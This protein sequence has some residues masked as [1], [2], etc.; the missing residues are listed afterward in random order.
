MKQLS[1]IIVLLISFT[2]IPCF[3]QFDDARNLVE[4]LDEMLKDPEIFKAFVSK[5][6]EVTGATDEELSELLENFEGFEDV[7]ENVEDDATNSYVDAVAA[8]ASQNIVDN[9]LD[10]YSVPQNDFL[11]VSSEGLI[12]GYTQ[13]QRNGDAIENIST[14]QATIIP[15]IDIVSVTANFTWSTNFQNR[16]QSGYAECI[17]NPTTFNTTWVGNFN[18][19]D[20]STLLTVVNTQLVNFGEIL[21][22][23]YGVQDDPNL[24]SFLQEY[25]VAYVQV[26]LPIII[27]NNI[28][29]ALQ[30]TLD[31]DPFPLI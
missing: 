25:F 10:K 23:V 27:D 19:G 28:K 12:Q 14:T 15:N 1:F 21:V 11:G 17:G 24:I 5:I 31:N 7:E 8:I 18:E 26:F 16:S 9:N 22:N 3:G 4:T 20:L 29:A 2:A 30:N 6:Q 13:L